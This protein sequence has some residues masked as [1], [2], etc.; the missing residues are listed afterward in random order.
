MLAWLGVGLGI[1]NIWSPFYPET[2]FWFRCFSFLFLRWVSRNDLIDCAL[3]LVSA[4]LS[5]WGLVLGRKGYFKFWRQLWKFWSLWILLQIYW[6]L[7][8]HSCSFFRMSCIFL[9]CIFCQTRLRVA[10]PF[11]MFFLLTGHILI[12]SDTWCTGFIC[13][14]D[15]DCCLID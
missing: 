2:A 14:L 7:N 3:S 12:R 1:G 6:V 15:F 13:L 11:F 9:L 4:L 5:R 8:V 10:E